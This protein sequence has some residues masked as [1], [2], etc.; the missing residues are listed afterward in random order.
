MAKS[1]EQKEQIV[2]QL[3]HDF[4][5]A[6]SV[7]FANFQGLTVAETEELRSKA[8]AEGVGVYVAKKT[9]LERAVEQSDIDDVSPRAFDGGVATFFGFEDVVAPAKIV[10][11]FS[12][13]H[14]AVEILGGAMEGSGIAVE[15]VKALAALPSK[16][17]LLAKLVGSLNA[18]MSGFA[19]VLAGNLR[20]LVTVLDGI[21]KQKA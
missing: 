10:H 5:R 9:L 17:E 18:P 15:Q 4:G 1:K 20:G 19:N 16:Q 11:E 12:K 7:V 3:K 21:A 2:A 8:R 6:K 14:E 13:D